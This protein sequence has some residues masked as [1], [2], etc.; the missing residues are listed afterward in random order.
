M[1]FT[2]VYFAGRVLR[3]IGGLLLICWRRMV[4]AALII[5]GAGW[6]LAE[7]G[8]SGVTHQ[9]P[10]PIPAQIAAIL[11]AI[12][13]GYG[14]ALTVLLAE[15]IG[16]AVETIRLLEGEAGAGARAA[17]VI[18]ERAEGEL[19]G[20]LGWIDAG[21]I[22]LRAKL[23]APRASTH[24][25]ISTQTA[26]KLRLSSAPSSAA[27]PKDPRKGPRASAPVAQRPPLELRVPP[28]VGTH[29]QVAQPTAEGEIIT[30]NLETLAEIAATEEF[31]NTAPRPRVNARPVPANQLPRIEWTYENLGRQQDN[32]HSPASTPHVAPLEWQIV[33]TT[34][35]EHQPPLHTPSQPLT[36]AKILPATGET[37]HPIPLPTRSI[38]TPPASSESPP[39]GSIPFTP[40]QAEQ[41]IP[42]PTSDNSGAHWTPPP[43]VPVISRTSVER[44]AS[45][46]TTIPLTETAT[47]RNSVWARIS[48]ALAG[49]S[50][51]HD[52]AR[53]ALE[54]ANTSSSEED[55]DI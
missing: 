42:P 36:P 47:E 17:A 8:G 18:S 34:S 30:F 45:P 2:A 25:E 50:P 11:F 44:D 31:V 39:T 20:L 26:E 28:A 38:T 23:T 3:H 10:A 27:H 21:A 43:P 52:Q 33:P 53:D 24:R 19:S 46:R 15:I 22:A 51:R 1:G 14:A 35:E 37:L 16:G 12:G 4:L 6:L 55:T 48:R 13:L 32:G 54:S 41:V 7:V 9:I 29:A 49:S 5:G 40:L